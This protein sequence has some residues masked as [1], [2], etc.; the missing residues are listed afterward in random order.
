MAIDEKLQYFY[1]STIS[2]IQTAGEEE[3][4]QMRENLKNEYEKYRANIERESDL[5]ERLHMMDTRREMMKELS[6][7]KLTV[8]RRQARK[9]GAIKDALF[10]EVGE[11]L[12]EFRKTP[13]YTELLVRMI[14]KIRTFA[15]ND[16]VKVYICP[17]DAHL[18]STIER[19]LQYAVYVS[20][21]PFNG[22]VQA[23]IPSR[24]IFINNSF[25]SRMREA[26]EAFIPKTE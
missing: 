4:E 21:V 3:L 6:Y 22:G 5:Q 7:E 23:E 15:G 8:R 1:D 18:E 12:D 14:R 20:A 19:E 17:S 16:E 26:K 10:E 13:A 2:T 25:S 9:E 24:N 11:M